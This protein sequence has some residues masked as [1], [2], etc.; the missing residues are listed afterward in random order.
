MKK[1]IRLLVIAFILFSA[2]SLLA[3]SENN[4]KYRTFRVSLVPGLSTNGLD[5]PNYMSK[6][7]LNIIAGYNGALDGYE[8]GLVN[9]N[10]VYAE[11]IQI[12]L[13]NGTG[14]HQAGLSFASLGNVAGGDVQG[15]QFGGLVNV[16]G[17]FMQGLQ[18]SGLANVSSGSMQGLQFAGLANVSGGTTQG[19]H[20]SGLANVS[21]SDMQGIMGAGLVNVGGGY[22]QG[23][24]MAGLVNATEEFQGIA[25]SGLVNVSEYF[26]GMQIAGLVNVAESGEGVQI[27]VINTASRF[28]GVP[29]GL[30]SIYGDGRKNVDFWATEAGFLHAGL[31]LGTMDIYNMV[32]VDGNGALNSED[33][34]SIGWTIGSHAPLEDAWSN[35]RFEGYFRMKD[36]SIRSIQ[37]EEEDIW[38]THQYTYRYLLGKYI[39]E[40]FGIYLGPTL[41]LSVSDEDD[42]RSYSWYS[43]FDANRGDHDYRFWIGGTVGLQLF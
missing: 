30:I 8:I 16:S 13:Y 11:G 15:L 24:L 12:G 26:Q 23:I 5:A 27:G 2:Q 43:I 1:T 42:E 39:T 36:F 3:Q 19:L 38:E 41:N 10:R 31:K 4:L 34:W 40:S 21:Q 18:F 29:V 35:D 14:G 33:L 28:S 32:S 7:S 9:L 22:T 25:L 6:Y 37:G 20:F 17:G